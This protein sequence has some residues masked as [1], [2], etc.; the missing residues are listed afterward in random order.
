MQVGIVSM[1]QSPKP[2]KKLCLGNWSHFQKAV[3]EKAFS[4]KEVLSMF[5]YFH[6]VEKVTIKKIGLQKS[7]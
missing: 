7:N 2:E 6:K 4:A 1:V 3:W 5:F